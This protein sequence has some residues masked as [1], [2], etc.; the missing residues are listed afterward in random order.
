[1]IINIIINVIRKAR[2]RKKYIEPSAEF[3]PLFYQ[4]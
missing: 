1:M 4:K 3:I 2:D